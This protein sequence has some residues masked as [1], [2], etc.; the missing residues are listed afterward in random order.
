MGEGFR[1]PT[2]TTEPQSFWFFPSHE[3]QMH[4]IV[5]HEPAVLAVMLVGIAEHLS[6]AE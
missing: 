5:S 1:G 6:G 2:G 4:D 3:F